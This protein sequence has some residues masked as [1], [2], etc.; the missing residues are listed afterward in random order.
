[1]AFINNYESEIIDWSEE[2][3]AG[4]DND[5]G[6]V[7]VKNSFPGLVAFGFSLL[8]VH[9][10]DILKV[11]LEIGHKLRGEGDFGDEK[12]GRLMV[13]YLFLGELDVNVCLTRAGDAVEE[14]S[15]VGVFLD[16]FD[17]F[18]LRRIERE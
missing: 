14:N 13:F 17:S 1:M 11:V 12:N 10:N 5:L 4:P 2:S 3:R 7:A 9:E 16:G 8:R 6:L 15:R 18:L